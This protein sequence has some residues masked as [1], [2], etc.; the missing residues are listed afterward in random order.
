MPVSTTRLKIK[1]LGPIGDGIAKPGPVFVE[2]TAPGDT[3]LA[4]VRR[5]AKGIQRGE[6]VEVVTPS[7]LRQKPPC[8]H[9]DDCG[10]CTLQ[11]LA[12]DYYYKWK[13]E[14]VESIL[15]KQNV[16]PQR[17]LEPVLV[18]ESQRRRATL[19]AL[20]IT[21]NRV[22]IGYYK[23][24]SDRITDI[25]EC[26]IAHPKLLKLRSALRPYL[27]ELLNIGRSVDVFI[28][29]SGDEV[30]V[31]LT[32]EVGRAGYVDAFVKTKLVKMAED[33]ELARVSW[34]IGYGE[35]PVVICRRTQVIGHFGTLQV[36]LPPGAF[37]QPTQAG[38]IAL[39][40]GVER[41][42]PRSGY[43]ADLFAGCGSFSG[44]LENRGKV[45]AFEI[46]GAA[47]SAL[48]KSSGTNLRAYRRDLLQ[49][50]LKARELNRYDGVVFDP[51]R[52][53]CEEQAREMAICRVPTIVSVSCNPLTFARDAA[54]LIRGGYQLESV[55]MVDQFLWSHHIELVGVFRRK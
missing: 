45:D 46:E 50:P 28:Q 20:K 26:L 14:T 18:G 53:G 51:P 25:K 34:R 24:R 9:Y 38:E 6:V 15:K 7:P 36:P 40:A 31:L 11:H 35:F 3:I 47:V 44:R 32:G 52:C 54:I 16:V 55:Q 27:V 30:D 41:A 19:S 48:A 1:G 4:R 29:L 8:R 10:N 22:L 12:P 13:A 5:D 21:Q 33:L 17:W 2:R 37:L 42:F 39:S 23:R 49:R 43:F